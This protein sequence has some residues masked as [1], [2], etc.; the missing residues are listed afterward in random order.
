M[1]QFAS[2][3]RLGTLIF[4]DLGASAQSIEAIKIQGKHRW[5]QCKSIKTTVFC[6]E[7]RQK[8]LGENNKAHPNSSQKQ[9]N[10]T[11][12]GR[13]YLEPMLLIIDVCFT[14]LLKVL[15]RFFHGKKP[16]PKHS[17]W[18]TEKALNKSEKVP[19]DWNIYL[20]EWLECMIKYI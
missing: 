1:Y 11:V 9:K 20:H 13:V 7:S 5:N 12:S 19:W 4:G 17:R 2:H 8:L 6:W 10:P 16:S 14:K 3:P 15:L 18:P